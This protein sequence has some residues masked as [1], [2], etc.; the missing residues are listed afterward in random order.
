[1]IFCGKNRETIEKY[2]VKNREELNSHL[3]QFVN[4]MKETRSSG[5]VR[6]PTYFSYCSMKEETNCQ[7]DSTLMYGKS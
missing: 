7:K 4:Y 6:D 5:V 3:S 1:M 2:L